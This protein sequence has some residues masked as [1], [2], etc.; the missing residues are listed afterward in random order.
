MVRGSILEYISTTFLKC[1]SKQLA[2][3]GG[4]REPTQ[5]LEEAPFLGLGFRSPPTGTFHH[6]APNVDMEIKQCFVEAVVRLRK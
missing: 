3:S 1:A 6:A 5:A 2:G 4:V